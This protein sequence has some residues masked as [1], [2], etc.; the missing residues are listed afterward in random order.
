MQVNCSGGL[1]GAFTKDIVDHEKG[2]RES[3]KVN[4]G[5]EPIESRGGIH[6]HLEKRTLLGLCGAIKRD[7]GSRPKC[8]SSLKLPVVRIRWRRTVIKRSRLLS[9]GF[10]PRGGHQGSTACE[11]GRL[12]RGASSLH[13][14]SGGT[15]RALGSFA[16][17]PPRLP[18]LEDA[19]DRYHAPPVL[20]RQAGRVFLGET[21]RG[22]LGR[23][24]VETDTP[25]GGCGH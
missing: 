1:C 2:H 14:P 5:T 15:A 11:G 23:P 3:N 22:Q 17:G 24:G 12:D 18:L 19:A 9:C 20:S 21:H 10:L 4:D 8:P 25:A 6:R 7:N 13:T 16:R